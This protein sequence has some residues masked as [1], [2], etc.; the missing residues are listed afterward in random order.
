MS[1]LQFK[2]FIFII[3]FTQCLADTLV[4]IA[5]MHLSFPPLFCYQNQNAT[6]FPS[7]I[8]HQTVFLL[9]RICYVWYVSFP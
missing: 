3:F 9:P 1:H 2:T 4:E 6:Y 5:F 7:L 8:H